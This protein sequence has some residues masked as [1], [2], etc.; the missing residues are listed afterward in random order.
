MFELG[1][2]SDAEHNQI[3]HLAEAYQFEQIILIGEN[4]LKTTAIGDHVK[5]YKNRAEFEEVLKTNFQFADNLLVKGS[6][7]MRLDLL[8]SII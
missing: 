2:T 6:H 5:K 8:T 3:L 4:F 1:E 7:G